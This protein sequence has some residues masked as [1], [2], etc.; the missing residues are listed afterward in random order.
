MGKYIEI[1]S[2]DFSQVS[3]STVIVLRNGPEIFQKCDKVYIV[4]NGASAIY[5]TI[6]GT[7]PTTNSTLYTQPLI[8]ER[9]VTI[10]KAIAVINGT[11]TAVSEFVN[12][13]YILYNFQNKINEGSATLGYNE[14]FIRFHY[15]ISSLQDGKKYRLKIELS[16]PIPKTIRVGVTSSTF[17]TRL[18]SSDSVNTGTDIYLAK[19]NPFN[20]LDVE[21]TA[22]SSKTWLYLYF[23]TTGIST[24]AVPDDT[25]TFNAKIVRTE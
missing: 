16:K 22:D 17:T 1:K 11:S 5:Y 13:P 20:G 23:D 10:I 18:T 21:F 2:A 12:T 4:A 25:Y 7:T 14:V 15:N 19:L 8:I 9:N 24:L 6:D 3:L